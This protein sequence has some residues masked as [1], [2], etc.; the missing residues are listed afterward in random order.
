MFEREELVCGQL[1]IIDARLGDRYW[2]SS[3]DGLPWLRKCVYFSH[4]QT[5]NV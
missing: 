1:Q 5:P 3:F 2:G 4:L